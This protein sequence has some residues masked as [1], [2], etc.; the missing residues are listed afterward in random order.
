MPKNP[1]MNLVMAIRHTEDIE[2]VLNYLTHTYARQLLS[3]E[4]RIH[5]G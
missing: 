1:R 5:T 3:L 2:N 4:N